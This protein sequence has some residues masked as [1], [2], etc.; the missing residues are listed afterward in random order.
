MR[1][2]N[3]TTFLTLSTNSVFSGLQFLT[4]TDQDRKLDICLYNIFLPLLKLATFFEATGAVSIIGSN[5]KPNH[6]KTIKNQS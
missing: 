5:L 3:N 4:E 1:F 2:P 6:H